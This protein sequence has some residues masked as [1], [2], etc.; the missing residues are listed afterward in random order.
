MA[1]PG[2]ALESEPETPNDIFLAAYLSF[3]KGERAEA[4]GETKD[5][6]LKYER[7]SELLKRVQEKHPDWNPKIVEYRVVRITK[8]LQRLTPSDEA[9]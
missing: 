1:C 2:L 6:I 7:A 3:Q 5:A 8:A 4:K 9:K